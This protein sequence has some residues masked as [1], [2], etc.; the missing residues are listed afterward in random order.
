MSLAYVLYGKFPPRKFP[1]SK[2]HK[3]VL[4][5][6]SSYA[7]KG[8]KKVIYCLREKLLLK[9]FLSFHEREKND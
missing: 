6:F 7:Q 2:Q 8:G 3:N 4:P 5:Q 9:T 1:F